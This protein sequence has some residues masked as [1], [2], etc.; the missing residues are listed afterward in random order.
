MAGVREKI[1]G[2]DTLQPV[3]PIAAKGSEIPGQRGRITAEIEDQGRAMGK[4]GGQNS[5][6]QTLAGGIQQHRS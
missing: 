5:F 6:L 1:E 3:A 2:L 4:K